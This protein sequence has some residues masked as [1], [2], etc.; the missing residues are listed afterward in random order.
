MSKSISNS[1][2]SSDECL[3]E[4]APPKP[5]HILRRH[6]SE[7]VLGVGGSGSNPK[8]GARHRLQ[9]TG[10]RIFQELHPRH[11]LVH[12]ISESSLMKDRDK[13]KDKANTKVSK[14]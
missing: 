8:L 2:K 4:A 11:L 1:V 7:D 14:V 9:K 10:S 12:R 3:V 5:R 13:D 6:F